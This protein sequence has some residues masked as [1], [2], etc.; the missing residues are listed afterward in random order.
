MS[1]LEIKPRR[2]KENGHNMAADFYPFID[3]HPMPH[4]A[5]CSHCKHFVEGEDCAPSK[6]SNEPL[7]YAFCGPIC[8]VFTPKPG[9]LS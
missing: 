3:G 8:G 5:D 4:L 6:D 7:S 1:G 2:W 9:V